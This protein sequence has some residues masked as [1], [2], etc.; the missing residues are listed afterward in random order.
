MKAYLREGVFPAHRHTF[1]LLESCIWPRASRISRRCFD[2]KL[3]PLRQATDATNNNTAHCNGLQ[4]TVRFWMPHRYEQR[5][6]VGD[7]CNADRSNARS[8]E[9]HDLLRCGRCRV[10]AAKLRT[11]TT[12]HQSIKTLGTLNIT[13]QIAVLSASVNNSK[14]RRANT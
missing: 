1:R 9:V 8:C 14:P 13:G 7:S 11:Q 3:G 10:A 5:G 4:C 6:C 12:S 2:T